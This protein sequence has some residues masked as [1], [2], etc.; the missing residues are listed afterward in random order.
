MPQTINPWIQDKWLF[1]NT[2]WLLFVYFY[3]IHSTVIY[4]EPKN[5]RKPWSVLHCWAHVFSL[6]LSYTQ[7]HTHSL[8]KYSQDQNTF[9]AVSVHLEVSY[10][11]C[12][13]MTRWDR[14]WCY[15]TFCEGLVVWTRK[16]STGVQLKETSRW[17]RRIP[18]NNNYKIWA[19]QKRSS[20]CAH[21]SIHQNNLPCVVN[22]GMPSNKKRR[23]SCT[24]SAARLWGKSLVCTL[25][26]R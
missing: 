15:R 17:N 20:K 1:L 12:I 16:P 10:K 21:L 4:F 18:F 3:K 5:I 13:L 23:T 8:I 25:M 2:L 11:F 24:N 19:I 9:A 14:G 22:H 26:L 6:S 7:T